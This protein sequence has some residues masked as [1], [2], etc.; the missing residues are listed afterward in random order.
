MLKIA[1]R[2][3]RSRLFLGTGK[4]SSADTLKKT[5]QASGSEMITVALR[6]VDLNDPADDIM[7]VLDRE[8]YLFLPNTSGA[9]DAKE[10]VRLAKIA[11]AAGSGN[12]LKLEVTPDP[13]TLLPDPIETLKAT[14]ELVK[15][16]FIVLPYINADP[17]L[18]LRLQ[19]AGAAAVMPLGAP[20][21][22]NLGLITKF[23]VAIIIDQARVPV[24]VDAGLGSPSDA[25][26]AMEIGADAVLVNTAIS[27][28]GDPVTMAAAFAKAVEAGRSAYEAGLG[29][30][31]SEASASSPLTGLD[32]IKNV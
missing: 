27:V 1:D 25:A 3:F 14:E 12:W 9:R 18:A 10:A 29:R 15:D 30:K 11:R 6:R 28:A 5:I 23:Q 31:S 8:K 19:D 26:L 17:I 21:G 20:I 16:G 24:V 22:T 4:F 13:R 2:T 32:F 7:N